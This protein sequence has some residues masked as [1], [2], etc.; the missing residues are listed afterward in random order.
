M[1][2]QTDGL[3]SITGRALSNGTRHAWP[4]AIHL[5]VVSVCQCVQGAA[6]AKSWKSLGLRD[7]GERST[8]LA[9]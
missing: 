7:A 9:C 6:M 5:A 2:P 1:D 3:C 8:T 4:Y